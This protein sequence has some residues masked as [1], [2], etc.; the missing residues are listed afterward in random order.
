MKRRKIFKTII[1]L[2]VAGIIIGGGIGLY[3]FNMPHRDIQ[4]AD[5]DFSLIASDIVSEYLT[6]AAAANKKYLAADGNSKILEITGEI[7]E[8]YDNYNG[9]KVVLIKDDMDKAGVSATFTPETNNNLKEVEIGQ[10][11]TIKGVIRSGAS[12]DEDLE[13]YENVTIDKSDIVN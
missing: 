13:L 6:D 10:T 8:I 4:N 9:Q 12:Y 5:T 11:I 1:I 3:M 2:G 7:S